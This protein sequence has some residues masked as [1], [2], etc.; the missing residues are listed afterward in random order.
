MKV[1]IM[2]PYFFPYIGFFQAISSVD[3][4]I[5][6][7]ELNY[8][9]EGWV[10][11]NRIL[12]VNG[13]PRN[14]SVPVVSKSSSKKI[15]EVR[16]DNTKNWKKKM[17]NSIFLNYKKSAYFDSIFPTIEKVFKEDYEYLTELN[18]KSIYEV[19]SLLGFE[20]KL[21][22]NPSEYTIIEE[23]IKMRKGSDYSKIKDLSVED[24]VLRIFLI[25]ENENADTFINSIGGRELYCKQEF[26]KNGINL[27]FVQTNKFEYQQ[28]SEVFQPNLSIID[29]LMNCGIENTKTFINKY[30]LV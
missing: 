14:I 28:L 18:Y 29:V 19:S 30:E 11:K 17:L 2:Q 15:S 3:K 25:C 16:I 7:D 1:A 27:F 9:K 6:Y 21:Y 24:K 26:K 23:R 8:I 20:D 22:F 4:Y 12:I 5:I 13:K 10:N